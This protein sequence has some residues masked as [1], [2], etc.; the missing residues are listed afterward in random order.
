[1]QKQKHKQQIT[2]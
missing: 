1:M 2:F